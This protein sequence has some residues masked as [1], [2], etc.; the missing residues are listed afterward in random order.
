MNLALGQ[1]LRAQGIAPARTA[2]I[3]V[4]ARTGATVYAYHSES[5]L[6]PAS[7][8]KLAVSYTALRVLGPR[9]RFRT[10]VVGFGR[11]SGR[12]WRGNVW[13]VGFGDPTLALSDLDRLAR[14]FAATGIRRIA[15][16]V[17]GDDTYFDARRDA[18]GWK[19][20]YV[21]IESRP[22]SALSVAGVRLIGANGSAVAAARAYVEALGRHGVVVTGRAGA[23]PAPARALSIAFDL[24]VRVA[25]I[26][27]RMNADSDNFVAEMVLKGLGAT[28]AEPGSTAEGARVVRSTLR[29]A[30]VPLAGVRIA[31]GSGLSH[32]DRVTVRTLADI[33]R[34]GATDRRIG[35]IFVSSLAVAGV[36][37]TLKARLATRPTRGRIHAK[38][39][40][41]NR[42]SA[43]AGLVGR[44]YVF[45]ILQNGSP[46]PY[47]TARLA[48]DRF[49]TVLARS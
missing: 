22:L 15:G 5:S 21:G 20:S 37:G 6:L 47:W 12:T 17:L 30:G 3:A 31:D 38:T 24:S 43:L 25:R 39:G 16:R 49:V 40:T 36:S 42:A 13:L 1:A 4:D 19:F 7:A 14:R 45:A 41:T 9:Y 44:K 8:E 32:F 11:R 28:V 46:V 2:A 27:P 48:Q 29:Q 18:P 35:E 34:A 26:V 23:R 10:E 33:L